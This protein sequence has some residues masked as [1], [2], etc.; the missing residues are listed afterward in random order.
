MQ[1]TTPATDKF[2][3]S[4][5]VLFGP[6]GIGKT[7][8][9][10]GLVRH[11]QSELGEGSAA[12][13]TAAD[14]RHRLNDAVKR[15]A[16]LEFRTAFR[17]RQLLAIDD[18]QHLPPDDHV[19]QVLRYTLDDYQ[20][21][22]GTV[23]VTS[24][25]PINELPHLPPDLRSRLACGLA[26][27]LA[28]PGDAARVRIIR[29][30]AH[31][32]GRPISEEAADRL[33]HGLEGTANDLHGAVFQLAPPPMAIARTTSAAPSNGSPL[34]QAA[35][36]RSAKSRPSLPVTRTCR[37]RSLKAARAANRSCSPAASSRFWLANSP[38]RATRKS[39]EHSA[40]AIVRPSSTATAKLPASAS[41]IHKHN[42]P[43]NTSAAYCFV[44][45]GCHVQR[46]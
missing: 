17:G 44:V 28:P 43:W 30:A 26:L 11:W 39:A 27:Q 42:K 15:Q 37:N 22:G 12:Y 29:H 4:V 13:T 25:S 10:Q 46:C 9:A 24:T 33:A 14:F 31:A 20:D 38:A 6:S 2:A 36:R 45:N 16:E 1:S 3:P 40:D 8:L 18:L 23:V 41:A 5:L 32:L 7:H 35:G 21:R 19:L 34:A